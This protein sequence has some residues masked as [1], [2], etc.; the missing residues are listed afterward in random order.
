M[1][2]GGPKKTVRA[3]TQPFGVSRGLSSV[4]MWRRLGVVLLVLSVTAAVITLQNL[5]GRKVVL[6]SFR[7]LEEEAAYRD[8]DQILNS[9]QSD[10]GHLS[11]SVRDYAW[12]DDAYAYVLDRNERFTQ[13]NFAH[14]SLENMGVDVV[15]MLDSQGHEILSLMTSVRATSVHERAAAPDLVDVLRKHIDVIKKPRDR[16]KAL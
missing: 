16:S 8:L 3:A 5:A 10:L 13:S 6:D 15:W 4:P 11:I 7:H 12:W 2:A 1:P 14:A 9:F